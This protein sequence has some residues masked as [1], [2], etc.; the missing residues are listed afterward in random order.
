MMPRI[1][2]ALALAV[3]LA[4]PAAAQSKLVPADSAEVANH[5]VTEAE[6]ARVAAIVQRMDRVYQSDPRAFAGLEWRMDGPMSLDSI[7]ARFESKP[8]M[9]AE[10]ERGGMTGRA[11]VVPL[12][13]LVNA[14]ADAEEDPSRLGAAR[15]ANVRFAESRGGEI[16]RLFIIL[17]TVGQEN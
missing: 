13:A 7:G 16:G 9:R 3:S 10:L 1:L 5:Q 8:A 15:A 14:R 11:F 12:F 4:A 6:L 17:R 2:F